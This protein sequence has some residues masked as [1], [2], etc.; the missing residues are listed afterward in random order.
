VQTLVSQSSRPNSS[1][2]IFT[3]AQSA[4]IAQQS[5]LR[6]Y[7]QHLRT[8]LGADVSYG[9]II[10]DDLVKQSDLYGE[11]EFNTIP[12]MIAAQAGVELLKLKNNKPV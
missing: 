8:L 12:K 9:W 5:L 10:S 4:L 6:Q 3:A 11:P 7:Q 1:A 2:V